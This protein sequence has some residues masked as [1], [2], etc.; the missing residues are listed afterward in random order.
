[1]YESVIVCNKFVDSRILI[2]KDIAMGYN[3]LANMR[4]LF[5]SLFG[6][7]PACIN[8]EE[9]CHYIYICRFSL[10]EWKR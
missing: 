1:M 3:E 9:H 4:V 6:M 8:Y 2:D 7:L 10:Y 5:L